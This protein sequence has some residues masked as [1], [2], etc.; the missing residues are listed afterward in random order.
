[1]RIYKRDDVW[2]IDYLFQGRRKRKVIG[3]NRKEAESVL[4]KIRAQI[5]EGT[6]FDVKRNE[7]VRFSEMAKRYMDNH[8]SINNSPS[9]ITRTPYLINTLLRH[10]GEKYLYEIRELDI[11]HYK[12]I[13]LEAGVKHATINR[14]LGLFRSILNKAKA[15]GIIK[16][17]PPKIRTFKVDNTRTRYLNEDEAQRLVENCEEPLKSIVLLALNTGMRRGEILNLRWTDI[18]L[19]ERFI[20]VRDTKSKKN[21]HI[22]MN[23]QTFDLLHDLLRRTPGDY[24]F[25]GD[26]PGSHL[27]GSYVSNWFRKT[28][29]QTEIKDFHFH[30]LRHT[31]ASWL[32]MSGIDLTT[33][34]QL[35]GHQ[36]YQMTLKYAH[37][38]PEHRQ[39]A[40]DVLA[41]KTGK[42][43]ARRIE[44]GTNLAQAE[45]PVVLENANLVVTQ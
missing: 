44:H 4:A 10:F 9:T 27:S 5:V 1:M 45:I 18:N 30:D 22:P 13:R 24:V 15:W 40:V 31:C 38:S 25:P 16:S 21:R 32:V 41:R 6:Y 7:K 29:R 8:S 33:V 17:E 35:L 28:V 3:P 39:Y 12:K 20:T 26:K 19:P 23:Q 37:L 34:Q 11:D 42:L 2:C 36:T 14:E 43:G